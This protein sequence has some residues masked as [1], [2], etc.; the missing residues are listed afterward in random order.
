MEPESVGHRVATNPTPP[1]PGRRF[2]SRPGSDTSPC[3]W[4]CRW[5]LEPQ[6]VRLAGWPAWAADAVGRDRGS[7][8]PPKRP[9]TTRRPWSSP[10]GRSV[11][12]RVGSAP[13][14]CTARCPGRFPPRSLVGLRCWAA[15]RGGDH[16]GDGGA[17]RRPGVVCAA[18]P[19]PMTLVSPSPCRLR[20]L[21]G[22]CCARSRGE[23]LQGW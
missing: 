13:P 16:P 2:H 3:R 18:G 6:G 9:P 20:S 12:E 5:P 23:E 11:T 22:F 19:R 10:R 21:R 17:D 8:A 7:A 4:S 15:D 1:A 14:I